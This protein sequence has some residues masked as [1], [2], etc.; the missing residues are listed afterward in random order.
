MPLE[1]ARGGQ[2]LPQDLQARREQPR[3]GQVHL[4]GQIERLTQAYLAAVIA[5]PAY[6]RR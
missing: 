6:Q 4:E 1:R 3:R 5:L 2:R